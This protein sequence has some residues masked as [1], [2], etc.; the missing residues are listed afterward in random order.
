[1]D[2]RK[3]LLIMAMAGM[4]GSSTLMLGTS[5]FAG[6]TAK[7]ATDA[8]AT[9]VVAAKGTETDA[10]KFIKTADEALNALQQIRAARVAIFNGEP[11]NAVKLSDVAQKDLTTAQGYMN[12]L[13]L[14]TQKSA[15]EGD[16]YIPFDASMSLVEGFVPDEAE[17]AV[18]T[19]ANEHMAKGENDDAIE[20]LK[21]GNIDV[22][23]S[24]A[25]IP[26]TSS[27]KHVDDAIK[28]LDQK[29]YY[30][31]NLALKAVEDSV[32]IEVYDLQA[33]PVQG[34]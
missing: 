29:K 10:P 5:S 26:A 6:E 18:L 33:I 22:S 1:M 17:T 15:D 21:L 9:E 25:L 7:A 8:S 13:A 12:E 11:E 30:E 34:S 16:A 24:T 23:V 20:A 27:L 28:L 4:L 31:A 19:K 3:K 14:K 32:L 2:T